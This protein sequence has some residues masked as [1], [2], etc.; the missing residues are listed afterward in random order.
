MSL[1][2]ILNKL[3]NVNN[4]NLVSVYIP[5]AGKEMSF[6]PLSIKQQKDLI[7][8][9]MDGNLAGVTF[10]NI[11]NQIVLDNS[12]EKYKF[13]VTDRYPIIIA[14]RKQAFGDSFS[15]KDGDKSTDFDLT[16]I[17]DRKLQFTDPSSIEIL[18]DKTDLLAKVEVISIDDDIKINNYQI[19]KLKKSKDNE[20]ISETVGSLF[21]YEILKFVTKITIGDDDVDMNSLSIKDRVSVIE[22][23]PVTLNNSILSYIQ[24]LRK[25]END[26]ISINGEVLPLDPR[27][28]SKE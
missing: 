11:I 15:L 22:S 21:I 20:D 12:V 23:L 18:L 6:T 3:K 16:V 10:S 19:D 2:S 9:S 8:S 26:Y 17:L 4:S 1:P 28:F 25:D 14:L 5:S 27:F 7:K 24:A 13:L